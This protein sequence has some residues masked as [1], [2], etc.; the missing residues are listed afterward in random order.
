[1]RLVPYAHGV[2]AKRDSVIIKL[3]L[4]SKLARCPARQGSD[5]LGI[6]IAPYEVNV[7]I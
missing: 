7:A 3:D 6:V 2:V 1:M 4:G 5:G